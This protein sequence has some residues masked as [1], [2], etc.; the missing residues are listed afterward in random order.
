M[1]FGTM[2]GYR[3]FPKK[4]TIRVDT[5]DCMNDKPYFILKYFHRTHVN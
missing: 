5:V 2:A 3:F 4:T 1:L